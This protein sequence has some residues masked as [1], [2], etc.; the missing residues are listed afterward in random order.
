MPP[1]VSFY[2]KITYRPQRPDG[3]HPSSPATCP[4]GGRPT[5]I[6]KSADL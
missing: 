2:S 1:K 5:A 6:S 3:S 4:G